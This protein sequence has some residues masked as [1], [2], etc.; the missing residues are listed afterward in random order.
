MGLSFLTPALLGG[1]AL[2]AV[3]IVLHLAMRRRPVPHIFPALRLLQERAVANRRR[4]RLRHIL[5]LVVRMAALVLLAAALSRP[6]LKGAGW[7]ADTE[8][9]VAAAFVFDTAPRMALREGNRTRLE[10][11]TAMARVLFG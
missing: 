6:V 2:V 10:Q 8:A 11:A 5:L 9:P 3:P 7:L 4:L 1:A